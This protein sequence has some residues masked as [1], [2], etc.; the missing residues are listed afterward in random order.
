MFIREARL[1][2]RRAGE[3][4]MDVYD[5]D[6]ARVYNVIF[7]SPRSDGTPVSSPHLW[8]QIR[9]YD[10]DERRWRPSPERV[11][12]VWEMSAR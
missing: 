5:T 1:W 8:Q 3:R 2:A 9:G 4:L 12:G 6:F 10:L 11:H 7:M